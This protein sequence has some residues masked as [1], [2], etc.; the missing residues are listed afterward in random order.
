MK[1]QTFF[2]QE[3]QISQEENLHP[4]KQ[5]IFDRKD[6]L[7]LNYP[8]A[9]QLFLAFILL[10]YV[11]K[12]ENQIKNAPNLFGAFLELLFS[13]C[14]TFRTQLDAAYVHTSRFPPF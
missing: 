10:L 7:L 5:I 13:S 11:H 14:N 1:I 8:K 4:I 6:K 12:A 9:E 2:N 3:D